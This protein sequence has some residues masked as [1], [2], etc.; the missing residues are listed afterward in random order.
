[1]SQGAFGKVTIEEENYVF[2]EHY[3]ISSDD[4]D[5]NEEELSEEVS[6]L[7]L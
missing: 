5:I 3:D 6:R 2:D 7:K 1:M 4:S